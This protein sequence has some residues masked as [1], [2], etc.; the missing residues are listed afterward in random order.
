MGIGVIFKDFAAHWREILLLVLA[1]VLLTVYW[2]KGYHFYFKEKFKSRFGKS[3][4]FEWMAH[5][6]QFAVAWALLV[7]V[8]VAYIKIFLNRPLSDFG[9][10]WGRWGIGV[11]FVVAAGVFMWPFLKKTAHKPE[12]YNEY[13]LVH[14]L[15]GKNF[16]H[17]VAWELTYLTYYIPFE[18]IFRGFIQQGITLSVGVWLA[19]CFQMF[20][21]VIIHNNKPEGET[22]AAVGGAF[23]MGLMIAATGSLIWP[24]LFHW[25]IGAAT[26]YFCWV[27][28]KKAKERGEKVREALILT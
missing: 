8:P 2:Y 21:S 9:V 10:Q 18:F 14:G 15:Y 11:V 6:W 17:M 27:E 23:L 1:T 3:E 20:P 24:I 22:F 26:D 13:P 28:W 7:F 16:A 19:I 5:G 25:Y 4:Y 12:F